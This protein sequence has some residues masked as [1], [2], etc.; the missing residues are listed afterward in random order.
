MAAKA[1]PALG[2][3]P[4]EKKAVRE[5]I[6][7]VRSVY[8]DR[9]QHASLFGSK[10][11]RNWKK[12]SD[13]DILLVV[14]GNDRKLREDIIYTSADID[15]KY[16]VL[17]DVRVISAERWQYYADIKAGLYQNITRD[18]VPIRFRKIKTNPLVGA[19]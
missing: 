14:E 11:R 3:L 5:F 13:V 9:I 10:A 19:R 18:A 4:K 2:L 15:L 12:Y 16:N 7:R 6:T 8:G 1:R 17:L